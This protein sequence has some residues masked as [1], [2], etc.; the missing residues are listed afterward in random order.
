MNQCIKFIDEPSDISA[1]DNQDY[2]EDKLIEL[3]E[4]MESSGLNLLEITSALVFVT[5]YLLS[6]KDNRDAEKYYRYLLK[7]CHAQIEAL[8]EFYELP[9]QRGA[10]Q[11]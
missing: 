2:A 7:Q 3:C 5:H 11:P 4:T 8:H 1:V 10:N 9:A 6:R